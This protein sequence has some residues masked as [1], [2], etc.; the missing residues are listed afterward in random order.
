VVPGKTGLITVPYKKPKLNPGGEYF[1]T[2][3]FSLARDSSWAEKGHVLAWE[4]FQLPLNVPS[5]PLVEVEKLPGLQFAETAE[6]VIITGTGFSVKVG[7]ASGLIET[8]E[9][10]G[11]PLLT[12]PLLPNFWRVPTDNDIGNKMPLRQGIWRNA[13]KE[14]TKANVV[15]KQENPQVVR[16]TALSFLM[17]GNSPLEN[18]Y[19]VYGNG[20]IIVECKVEPHPDLIDLPRLG[21][22]TQLA[23]DYDMVTWYGRGPQETYWDRC[24]GAAVGRY[25]APVEEQIHRY[26]RPQENG[27]KTDVRWLALTSKDRQGL[28]AVGMPLLY[29]GAWPYRMADLENGKHIYEPQ[30]QGIVTLNLDY[31]Q[32]GV[33]GDDSWGALPHPEYRLPPKAYSYRFRLTPLPANTENPDALITRRYE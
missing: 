11:Q 8:W 14:R 2:V 33:G 32:M 3:V 10:N 1:L 25:Q 31:R 24:S 23:G 19:T 20:D 30:D 29:A 6:T 13:G 15:V 4:Q 22:Q 17:A 9:V 16:V 12:A 28:L 7:K 21:M 27:N 26:V 18:N 5:L